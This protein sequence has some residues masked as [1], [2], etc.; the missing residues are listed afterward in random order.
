MSLLSQLCDCLLRVVKQLRE[1]LRRVLAEKRGRRPDAVVTVTELHR[2]TDQLHPR[3]VR[4]LRLLDETHRS[5]VL[6]T[7]HLPDTRV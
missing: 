3:P 5:H 1:H 6:V 4:E 2:G 7:K